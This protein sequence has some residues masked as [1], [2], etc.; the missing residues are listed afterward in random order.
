VPPGERFTDSAAVVLAFNE[1]INSRDVAALA[2]LMTTTHRFVDSV[3]ATTGGK[4]GCIEA[5]RGFFDSFPDYRNVFD[6][7]ADV[8][9]G[10]V[11]VRGRSECSV[12]ALDGP[13]DWRAAVLDGRVDLWQVSEPT[14]HT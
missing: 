8:G 7:V 6:H 12:P 5:W 2:D 11:V 3:G 13:A 10:L 14:S 9:D 4:V 1:A